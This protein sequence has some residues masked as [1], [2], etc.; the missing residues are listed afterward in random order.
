M[1]FVLPLITACDSQNNKK[2]IIE[3]GDGLRGTYFFNGSTQMLT[4][5][6]NGVTFDIYVM[7]DSRNSKE[8]M[9]EPFSKEEIIKIAE[10]FK[11]Y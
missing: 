6:D 5:E 8:N 3:F 2:E 1:V 4:W 7:A 10:S 11:K 9:K